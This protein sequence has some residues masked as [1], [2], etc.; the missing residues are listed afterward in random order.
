MG[1]F[2]AVLTAMVTPFD[3]NLKVD[4]DKAQRLANYLTENGSDG[5]VV[6]GT[7]G[8]SPTLSKDEKIQLF[9]AV[10]DAVGNDVKVIGGTGS[11]STNESIELS[12]AAEAT[13]VDAVM[14][15]V[16]YYNKPPQSGLFAHFSTIANSIALPVILYNVPSRTS[17]NLDAETVIRLSEISNIVALKEAGSDVSQITRV[18]AE[19]PNDFSVYCGQDE[20]N[21]PMLS[22]GASGFISVSSHV[23]GNEISE[24][25]R[26]YFSGD[27]IGAQRIHEALIS[28]HKVL[29]KV[30]NPIMVKA[31]MGIVWEEVGIPR[32]PLIEATQEQKNELIMVLDSIKKI[33]SRKS[34]VGSKT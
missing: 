12:Q 28:V 29:F 30:T 34:V 27:R 16:P 14:L 19:T 9:K 25:A 15:V 31:A 17:C 5:L 18:V 6:S 1:Q 32:L 23:V 21:L 11:N 7:T 8:E 2:G 33:T 24:M 10:K 20:W 3:E 4:L 26:L 13:G 22:L